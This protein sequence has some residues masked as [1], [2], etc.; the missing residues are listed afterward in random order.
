MKKIINY[1]PFF[2]LFLLPLLFYPAI[3]TSDWRSSSDV[4]VL[5]EF[6][7]SLLAITAG[8]MVLLHFFTTGRWFF[9][10]IS[11]GFV[12]IG[13]EEFVHAVFSFDRIWPAISQTFRLAISTTWLTGHLLLLI[14]LFIALIFGKKEVVP[15]KRGLNAV[16][17]NV[18]ALIFAASVALLIFISPFL[19][20]F[21][22]LGSTTKKLIELLLALLYFVAFLFYSNIYAKQ[23]SGS[24]LLWSIIACIIFQVLAHIFVFDAQVFYDS[25][26]DTAHLI[27][28]L[29]YFFPIFGVWGETLKLH[30]SAQAQVTDDECGR[31]VRWNAYQRDEIVGKSED[32]VAGTN[33]A[34]TI[35][36]DDRVL[37]GSKIANV[38]RSGI[39]ES[40]EGRVLLRGGPSFRWLL[41]TGRQITIDDRPFLVGIGIDITERKQAEE[42]LKA[43]LREKEVL[44]QEIQH[45]VK[46]NLLAISG[47][48]ALQLDRIKD[49][50]SK[51]AFI[52]TMNRINAMT[53]IHTRLYQSEDYALINFKEYMEELLLELSRSYGFPHENIITNIQDISIDV[54]TAIPTGLILNELVSNAMKH[55]F[56]DRDN[57]KITITMSK[58]DSRITLAISDNG[59]GVPSNIDFKNTESVGL[60]LLGQLVEQINGSMELIRDNGTRFII[61]FSVDQEKTQ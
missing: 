27:V 34:D 55:A 47:I 36:P 33:A 10:I 26:W 23:Q 42:A 22:Q 11:I 15:A 43:S 3:D 61:T 45:R 59:I 54:N 24:P 44:L 49:D 40:V 8:I 25:H 2:A 39:E 21:V 53:R 41:M 38:L 37:I 20:H 58:E 48:L 56:P 4:H 32:Q 35:H 18:I 51:D 14:S 46:N 17:Y 19:P 5:F 1:L 12:Q 60:S 52:T 57:R 29:S 13:T 31:Y 7:S 50:E 6:A 28:F 9:L 30:R 16:V